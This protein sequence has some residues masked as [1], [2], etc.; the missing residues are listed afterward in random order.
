MPDLPPDSAD[1][2]DLLGRLRQGD[3][4]ALGPLLQRCRPRMQALV[5]VRLDPALRARVDPSDV[6]Q[7][8]Q[9]EM[10]S[11][12]DDFLERRPMPFH[13][14]ARKTAYGAS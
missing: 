14:W 6:V 8:A 5:E 11:R 9:M 13:L 1:T 12:I 10:V 4:E 2:L 3:R 7:E